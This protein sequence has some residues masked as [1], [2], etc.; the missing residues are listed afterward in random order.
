MACLAVEER[1][2]CARA[3]LD[4]GL[5]FPVWT[6]P[7]CVAAGQ[8]PLG[9][10]RERKR[11]PEREVQTAESPRRPVRRPEWEPLPG[12]G[13]QGQHLQAANL[14]E[15]PWVQTLRSRGPGTRVLE[16]LRLRNRVQR[17]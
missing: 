3:Y 1:A 10:P 7:G 13:R 16:I 14:G 8:S 17:R 11:P 4:A 6:A 12:L 2:A 5:A 15:V 9:L